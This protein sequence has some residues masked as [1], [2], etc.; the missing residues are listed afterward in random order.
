MR[1]SKSGGFLEVVGVVAT[2]TLA[3]GLTFCS[4]S[5]S[6]GAA[7]TD[8]G[9]G[10]TST[11]DGGGSDSASTVDGAAAVEACASE[12]TALC[13]LRSSCSMTF[14]ISRNFPDLA[15]CVSR[16]EQTCVA[17]LAASGTG[18]TPTG[19]T[20]CAAAYPN[21]ACTDYF[22]DD[23]IAACTPPAGSLQ[24]GAACGASA[25]CASTFCAIPEYQVCGTCQPVPAVG[26]TCQVNADCGRNLAC[27]VADNATTGTCA[28]YGAS[29]AACLTGVA[30]C[31][32]GLAC[33]DDNV[34]M[35]TMGT[36]MAQGATVGAACD[37]TRKTA[38]NCSADLGL[39]CIPT[40]A[41]SAVG[42]CQS[43]MLVAAGAACGDIGSAPI[44]GYADCEASGLCKRATDTATTGTC[45]APAVDGASCDNDPTV[46]PPC[47]APAKCVPTSDAGTAGT[48]TVPDAATCL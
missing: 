43:I 41:G 32:A 2:T 37:G 30:P 11:G 40:A 14:N 38:P 34:T 20:A 29:G 33:V 26:A 47:L 44:T 16:T 31:A 46:G 19:V 25:Q 27:A 13:N 36:C 12:A 15:T 17:A 45:V 39:V 5:S 10:D 22:D 9:G 48:C 24:T 8:A 1:K 42:T 4:S 6:S 35:M 23:P 18:Q 7:P 28:A 21:E 3:I